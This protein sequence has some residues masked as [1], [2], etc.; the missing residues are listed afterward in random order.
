M[1]AIGTWDI[2][3]DGDRYAVEQG[4]KSGFRDLVGTWDMC[5][6]PGCSSKRGERWPEQGHG[7]AKFACAILS[8]R[9]SKRAV[10]EG[11]FMSGCQTIPLDISA[12]FDYIHIVRNFSYHSYPI[13]P[14]FS[15][16][17]TWSRAISTKCRGEDRASEY[18]LRQVRPPS[19]SCR[20]ASL[21]IA[22]TPRHMKLARRG[23]NLSATS[24][25]LFYSKPSSNFVF[26]ATKC[27]NTSRR[28]LI[29]AHPQEMFPPC[30]HTWKPS[31]PLNCV[32]IC[33][34]IMC[35]SIATRH[36]RMSSMRLRRERSM[37]RAS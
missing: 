9:R 11:G 14:R 35:A 33:W 15:R 13:E 21:A 31:I 34:A 8:I 30:W 1:T 22:R 29:P 7:I 2:C 26:R 23:S 28:W 19:S 25:H 10:K 36:R 20:C 4:G 17:S 3:N 18:R 24:S 37:R 16:R 12:I 27:G 5:D 6:R 32:C